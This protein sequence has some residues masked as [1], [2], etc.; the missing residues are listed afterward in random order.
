MRELQIRF[1]RHVLRCVA[2]W[3]SVRDETGRDGTIR[4][5]SR[6]VRRGL[7]QRCPYA[8][9]TRRNAVP[10]Q[11]ST[12]NALRSLARSP[13][14]GFG[15]EVGGRKR[16]LRSRTEEARVSVPSSGWWRQHKGGDQWVGGLEPA[17]SPVGVSQVVRCAAKTR[18]SGGKYRRREETRRDETR[19]GETAVA[20]CGTQFTWRSL[21]SP[22]PF[23]PL[24][25]RDLSLQASSSSS[26][27][28]GLVLREPQQRGTKRRRSDGDDRDGYCSFCCE[29][30]FVGK[31]RGFLMP[32][33][34]EVLSRHQGSA[35]C[36]SPSLCSTRVLLKP[37]WGNKHL[38]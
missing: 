2:H 8:A 7:H 3:N 34:I 29:T 4:T 14:Y 27:V 26:S 28:A 38:T 10:A 16:E 18:L 12:T 1:D 30:H 21:I 37:V 24:Q 25:Q 11:H 20:A 32:I 23:G 31:L 35:T 36:N 15:G 22:Q 13:S 9:K 5:T 17:A 33:M 6:P 19:R